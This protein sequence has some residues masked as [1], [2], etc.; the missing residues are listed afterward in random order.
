[1]VE[2]DPI[3][4]IELEHVLVDRPCLGKVASLVER[5]CQACVSGRV[6][7]LDGDDPPVQ[8]LRLAVP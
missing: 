7:G 4:G 5:L 3:G 1:M 8:L 2:R 6:V